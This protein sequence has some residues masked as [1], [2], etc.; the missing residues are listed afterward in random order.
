M[1]IFSILMQPIIVH[2]INVIPLVLV[3]MRGVTEHR[4]ITLLSLPASQG[5]WKVV[6]EGG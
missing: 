3:N 2:A 1:S 6:A 4:R 5:R